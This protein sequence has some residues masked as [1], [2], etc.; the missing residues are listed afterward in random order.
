MTEILLRGTPIYATLRGEQIA[1]VPEVRVSSKMLSLRSSGRLM[2]AVEPAALYVI[3]QSG[4]QKATLEPPT[5]RWLRLLA[6]SCLLA[7]TLPWLAR[8]ADRRG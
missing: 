4:V 8:K 3:D 5:A 2:T 7:P 6:M 1:L